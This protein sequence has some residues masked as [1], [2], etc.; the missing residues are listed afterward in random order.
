MSQPKILLL[1]GVNRT[2]AL[3]LH[4]RRVQ[5]CQQRGHQP[6]VRQDVGVTCAWC[7]LILPGLDP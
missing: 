2:L 7:G 6:D 5:D 3:A 1:P 4:H